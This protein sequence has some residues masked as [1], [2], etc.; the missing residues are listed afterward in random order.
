MNARS[1]RA[2]LLGQLILAL[3]ANAP[4]ATPTGALDVAQAPLFIGV[5]A[6]PNI[7]LVLNEIGKPGNIKFFVKGVTNHHEFGAEACVLFEQGIRSY[8]INGLFYN[9]AITYKPWTYPPAPA[10][11]ANAPTN[12]APDDPLA[13]YNPSTSPPSSALTSLT[14]G[15]GMENYQYILPNA[16]TAPTQSYQTIVNNAS[17]GYT[18]YVLPPNPTNCP[19]IDTALSASTRSLYQPPL[20]AP[21]TVNSAVDFTRTY[22]I[23]GQTYAYDAYYY[24]FKGSIDQTVLSTTSSPDI[25]DPTKYWRIDII[26]GRTYP[27]SN[28][29]NDFSSLE[30]RRNR[31]DCANHASNSCTY[32]EE[33]QNFANWYTYYRGAGNAARASLGASVSKLSSHF[34]I[35][36]GT[37]GEL[38]RGDYTDTGTVITP[39]PM[40][41]GQDSD[42]TVLY[43]VRP[44]QGNDLKKIYDALYAHDSP[45]TFVSLRRAMDD[46]GKY[47][48]RT[49]NCGP[50]SD[51]PG[52][53]DPA[54][55]AC[56]TATP[57]L[58]CRQNYNIMVTEN[59][60][61]DFEP[62][63]YDGTFS[64]RSAP[65]AL[66][67]ANSDA[68]SGVP[69]T[70]LDGSTGNT[71]DPSLT[72][73]SFY[74]DTYDGT[75][76]DYA[77]FYWK[78]DLRGDLDNTVQINSDDPA[79]WQHLV[80]FAITLAPESTGLIDASASKDVLRTYFT[81]G[82]DAT[83]SPCQ[84]LD[85]VG[86]NIYRYTKLSPCQWQSPYDASGNIYNIA[87]PSVRLARFDDVYHATINSRGKYY[88]GFNTDAIQR[89]I[90]NIVDEIVAKTIA[91]SSAVST[92]STRLQSGTLVYQA[93]FNA[94]QWWGQLLAFE[95][96]TQ[97]D[98]EEAKKQNKTIIAGSIKDKNGNGVIEEADAVWDAGLKLSQTLTASATAYRDVRKIYSY[99]PTQTMCSYST[100]TGAYGDSA[101]TANKGIEF[102]WQNFNCAQKKTLEPTNAS[103]SASDLVNYLRGDN[104][105]EKDHTDGV[106]RT[107]TA[108]DVFRPLG[109]IVDSDPFFLGGEDFGY[110]SLPEGSTYL[111]FL[112][113]K[114]GRNR[115]LFAGAND[116]MLHAF[117]AGVYHAASG[118][119]AAYFDQGDGTEL[120]AY[121][122]GALI[123]EKLAVADV[124]SGDSADNKLAGRAA[125]PQFIHK[126][127]VDGSPIVGD[128][129]FD[130]A[131]HS[132]LLGSLG[133]GGKAVFALDVTDPNDF[134]T[135]S[136]GAQKI[137]WEITNVYPTR[138]VTTAIANEE[139]EED[140]EETVTTTE[141]V[142][143]D[144]GYTIPQPA[145]ARMANG[146][147]A[148]IIGNGYSD[149]SDASPSGKA[150]LYIVDAQDGTLIKKIEACA[151]AP[152]STVCPG[153]ANNGLSSPTPVDVNDD[154]RVDFIY[155]GDLLGNLWKFDVRCPGNT[156]DN[157]ACSSA[158]GVAN[159]GAPLFTACEE[160]DAAC[161]ASKR[162]PI[163][164]KPQVSGAG[165]EQSNCL[166]DPTCLTPTSNSPSMMVYF[167]TGLYLQTADA[168][169]TQKQ[170]FYSL[171]D[172]NRC[173]GE[174]T[175]PCRG[176]TDKIA[177]RGG[178]QAQT[179]FRIDKSELSDLVIALRGSSNNPVCYDKNKP[180][181]PNPDAVCNPVSG[182]YLDLPDSG[183]RLVNTPLYRA[184]AT[185][186]RIVFSTLI[187]NEDP[188]TAGGSSWLMELNALSGGRLDAPPF[189]IYGPSGAPDG[190]IDNNDL[191]DYPAADN[192]TTPAPAIGLKLDTPQKTTYGKGEANPVCYDYRLSSAATGTIS[193]GVGSRVSCG[194]QSWRQLR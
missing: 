144:L 25:T 68:S 140:E 5:A 86:D 178:L 73:S 35:G 27:P 26:P 162:Q 145:L 9:P 187:P 129:Y 139:D 127:L 158:W 17:P 101:A 84:R 122:P 91:S 98:A 137:K 55:N 54:N 10:A 11:Y 113:T 179:T 182:W 100:S 168:T 121:V 131:W 16:Y 63:G 123:S 33:L 85:Y 95:V 45:A 153:T 190:K 47:F 186:A 167:G 103:D 64:Y 160:N 192:Q 133:A 48:M 102:L 20:T 53:P 46:V 150:V 82:G 135:I 92:N 120:F 156:Q 173:G 32:E 18:K 138:S 50:W 115:V 164:V 180:S 143:A 147:F 109:D 88:S 90:S 117:N 58:A 155:A 36:Y 170:S 177:Q 104:S 39:T 175:V 57:H 61:T 93:R 38:G 28:A 4:A 136:A 94:E 77:M 1:L 6:D 8:R 191:A 30:N 40:I 148:A 188:C 59:F 89:G 152:D 130:S 15:I 149:V 118:T 67:P 75:L 157:A 51:N 154:R 110:A 71:Y 108:E 194:S 193:T 171:W 76:A 34:R 12:K 14:A 66:S 99:N 125:D 44:F 181:D 56:V 146:K 70:L 169:D 185:A 151:P 112:G 22:T 79:F 166:R 87:Q 111:R 31:T 13:I 29:P 105:K 42:G 80:T 83:A 78:S 2:P 142:Y 41:D 134:L 52:S 97:K 126:F 60:W 174:A 163:A 114:S 184:T 72:E 128:A 49:D 132:V 65:P 69:V 172:K 183:E 165:L 189:D 74:K 107:R 159:N 24:I 161:P 37:S 96:N 116:G 119:A 43:G 176:T 21:S 141:P 19:G 7:M 62:G 106:Y 23:S 81:S 124:G 3:A